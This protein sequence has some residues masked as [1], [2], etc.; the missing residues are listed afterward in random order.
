MAEHGRIEVVVSGRVQGVGFRWFTQRE[1]RGLGVAGWVRNEPD[2]SVRLV[3]EGPQEAL[4]TLVARLHDG[5]SGAEVTSVQ[6]AWGV[7]R[8]AAPTFEIVR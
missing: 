7:A 1:A 6:T 5:P 4:E 3:A 2:G 8:E